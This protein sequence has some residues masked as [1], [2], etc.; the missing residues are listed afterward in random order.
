MG[1]TNALETI[2]ECVKDMEGDNR[3]FFLF[4]GKGD[5]RNR[6]VAET[7]GLRNVAFVPRVERSQVGTVLRRCDL[8]YFA[9][10]NSPVWK[11]GMSLNKLIDYMM[12]AKPVLAS[13]SGYPSMLD[14]SRCG[15]FV[16]AGDVAALKSALHRFAELPAERLSAMGEAG[17]NWL[18]ANRRWD[19]LADRYLAICDELCAA[20]PS[21]A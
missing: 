10:Q 13:Y 14:E 6:F 9:V 8:L 17:R 15:E 1:T 12:A 4:L 7:K 20:R 19:V 5:L 21:A 18:I 3:F 11:Y 2:I 16:P